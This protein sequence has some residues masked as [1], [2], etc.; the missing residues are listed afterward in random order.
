MAKPSMYQLYVIR[1]MTVKQVFVSEIN[2][3]IVATGTI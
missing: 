3:N 2:K 1:Y